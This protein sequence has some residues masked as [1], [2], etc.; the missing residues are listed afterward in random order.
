MKWRTHKNGNVSAPHRGKAP[1]CPDGYEPSPGNLFM[2]QPKI[3]ECVFRQHNVTKKSCCGR[4]IQM[5]CVKL[6]KNIRRL[7]CVHCQKFTSPS[8]LED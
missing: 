5:F 3:P 8:T 2:C 1:P 4:Y 7:S 6:D